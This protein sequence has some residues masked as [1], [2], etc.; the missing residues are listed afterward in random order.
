MKRI[1][2]YA[3]L[4][5]MVAFAAPAAFAQ[6]GGGGGGG[7]GRGARQM[8]MLFEG[9][10]LTEAQK[11]QTDS[12]A[13]FYRAQMPAFTP[14]QPPDSAARA[15]RMEIMEKQTTALRAVLTPD[16]QKLFDKNVETMKANMNR[17]RP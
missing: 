13:Q 11:T 17:P 10:T 2:V 8:Q 15:K 5:A 1:R 9:I 16:Q 12:I 6:G 14:G 7:Q 4:A 3:L